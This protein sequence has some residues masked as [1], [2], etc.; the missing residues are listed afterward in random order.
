MPFLC[1]RAH[2]PEA[3]DHVETV[4]G[5]DVAAMVFERPGQGSIDSGMGR[6]LLGKVLLARGLMGM[7][8]LQR[9]EALQGR[10]GE[11]EAAALGG[12]EERE[13]MAVCRGERPAQWIAVNIL[14]GLQ[15]LP[16]YPSLG[17]G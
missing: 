10:S 5:E 1:L 17:C 3:G 8:D 11:P 6:P 13:S 15:L 14:R 7:Y 16:Q 2:P 12:A 4:S 9:V